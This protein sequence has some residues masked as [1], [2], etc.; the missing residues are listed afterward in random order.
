MH[1]HEPEIQ[2][3]QDGV[4]FVVIGRHEAVIVPLAPHIVHKVAQGDLHAVHLDGG[5][6]HHIA[7]LHEEAVF[8]HGQRREGIRD[9]LLRVLAVFRHEARPEV[10]V[11]KPLPIGR[12]AAGEIH[13]LQAVLDIRHS[14]EAGGIFARPV[15]VR[16]VPAAV[17]VGN[18]GHGAGLIVAREELIEH[19]DGFAVASAVAH[20][21][22]HLIGQGAEGCGVRPDI[23]HIVKAQGLLRPV[24]AVPAVRQ[25]RAAQDQ[26]RKKQDQDGC[27]F[28]S[29]IR[30]P[31]YLS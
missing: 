19:G 28:L 1:L 31:L 10:L 13:V 11:F 22:H 9:L 8:L 4:I 3:A 16:K 6:G 30:A 23:G 7:V 17:D 25:G 12:G 15:F 18:G 24:R 27:Q 14:G 20:G 29:H 2:L 26:Q 21:L 5:R